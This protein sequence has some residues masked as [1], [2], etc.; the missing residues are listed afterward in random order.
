MSRHRAP[1][2]IDKVNPPHM[3]D[4]G[5]MTWVFVNIGGDDRGGHQGFG[6]MAFENESMAEDYVDDLCATFGVKHME[7]LVGKKCYVLYAFA[8]V[9]EMIA[10]LEACDTGKRFLHSAWYKRHH[11]DAQSVLERRRNSVAGTISLLQLR[12]A[13]AEKALASVGDQYVDWETAP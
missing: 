8:E 2:T 10:G 12:L 3:D 5:L 11:P 7:D 1:G 9:N 13:E 6:G 4:H